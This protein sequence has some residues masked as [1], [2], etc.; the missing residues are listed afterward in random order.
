M[1]SWLKL[2]H[3]KRGD[4][5][6]V[7]QAAGSFGA[8]VFAALLTLA[9]GVIL[10]WIA[11]DTVT[12]LT[13]QESL[14]GIWTLTL[15]TAAAGACL[16]VGLWRLGSL[17]VGFTTTAER[18]SAFVGHAYELEHRR[19]MTTSS[20]L[21][22]V[23]EE[24]DLTNSPGV[25]LRYRLPTSGREV[26]HV[27]NWGMAALFFS[28][29][30]SGILAVALNDL[31]WSA[32]SV[33]LVVLSI[34]MGG[35]AGF[36]AWRFLRHLIGW[37]RYGPTCFE[38]AALP[39]IPGQKVKVFVG[40]TGRLRLRKIEF[41]LECVEVAVYQQGTDVR[42]ETRVVSRTLILEKDRLEITPRSPWEESIDLEIP[43]AAMHSF[44]SSSNAI[45]WRLSLR[46]KGVSSPTLVR[47]APLLIY[48]QPN[49]PSW[50]QR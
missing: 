15:G 37:F 45:Q 24:A 14:A 36:G 48:P 47:E 3:K 42:R 30:T 4:R 41:A 38:I 1:P 5:T 22:N 8:S 21:P 23:P 34:L 29:L 7:P 19:R 27:V 25:H 43:P 35:I 26:W 44:V 2:L 32:A 13:R 31:R 9:G 12:R 39:T 20:R 49:S 33:S 50:L 6:T 16:A 11:A 18:R 10:V 40:Q 46:A 28:M 17:L